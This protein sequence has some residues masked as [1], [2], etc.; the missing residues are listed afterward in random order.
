MKVHLVAGFLGS[1]K[2]TTIIGACR[3]LSARG[4][5]VGVVTNDQGR[6]LV[7]TALFR[8]SSVPA[9][10]VVGGCFCCR[11]DDFRKKIRELETESRP[12]AVFAESVGSC[13]DIVATVVKPFELAADGRLA[14]FSVFVDIRL[15]RLWL[16]GGAFPFSEEV[17]YLFSKQIEEAGNVVIN[18]ADLLPAPE[19]EALRVDL[20]RRLPGRRVRLQSAFAE[21]DINGWLAAIDASDTG[22]ASS[23]ALDIDYDRYATAES[24]LAWYDATV[25]L[26]A[27]SAPPELPDELVSRITER[28]EA[29]KRPVGRIKLAADAGGGGFIINAR[30]ETAPAELGH[31][32]RDSL[33]E[34]CAEHRLRYTIDAE[35]CFR[36]SYPKPTHRI[37]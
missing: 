7:D 8:S 30:V 2:T 35:E 12:D 33:S 19:A 13:S 15:L 26:A 27:G 36:P 21:A 17:A 3:A 4:K 25:T 23:A 34:I 18:K 22:W 32:V 24:S 31:I 5:R 14:S 29:A 16:N 37:G 9:V 20:C 1:G 28:C 11:F 10:E 6:Y